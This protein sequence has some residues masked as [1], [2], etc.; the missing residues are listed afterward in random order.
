M[1]EYSAVELAD[2][3]EEMVYVLKSFP[4]AVRKEKVKFSKRKIKN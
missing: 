4:P 1:A 2:R 3:F